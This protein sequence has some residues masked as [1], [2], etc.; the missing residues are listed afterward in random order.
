MATWWSGR[1]PGISRFKYR[2]SPSP[3][4]STVATVFRGRFELPPQDWRPDSNRP[5]LLA[6]RER[7]PPRRT[8]HNFTNIHAAFA[9]RAPRQKPRKNVS[10]SERA[11]RLAMRQ[12]RLHEERCGLSVTTQ[13]HG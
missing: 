4:V 9:A 12:A 2:R 11:R 3:L 13:A 1:D 10:D 8:S 6:S 7:V 5:G